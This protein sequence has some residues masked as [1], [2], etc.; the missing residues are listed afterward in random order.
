[1]KKFL[2]S[3]FTGLFIF[4]MLFSGAY[5]A[6]NDP[7]Q[8]IFNDNLIALKVPPL[9]ADGNIFVP[10]GEISDLLGM[11]VAW[12]DSTR[13]VKLTFR[14]TYADIR[15]GSNVAVI[16]GSQVPLD[17]PVKVMGG[18]TYIPLQF[19]SEYLDGISVDWNL[20]PKMIR[21]GGTFNGFVNKPIEGF[22]NLY[23]WAGK[24]I[25]SI[26]ENKVPGLNTGLP[27]LQSNV[28][29]PENL[30]LVNRSNPVPKNYV[31]K[32]LKKY[33]NT[34]VMMDSD[35][36]KALEEMMAAVSKARIGALWVS[37]GYRSYNIQQMLYNKKVR[38]CRS[39]YNAK[40]EDYAATIV[41]RPGE[42]EHQTG[43]AIDISNNGKLLFSFGNT[44]QGKWLKENAY[45]FGYVIRY[46]TSKF[47]VTGVQNEPWHL[48]FV[49][50]R[51]A[52]IMHDKNLCLE[53][54]V[55]Y[56]KHL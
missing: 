20:A 26:P 13:T 11:K 15:L 3:V 7:I 30:L 5:A 22:I 18:K 38:E 19:V 51:H 21:M 53:E 29:L 17:M 37:S 34:S 33:K 55:E 47:R 56:L 8:V 41:A 46:E 44:V 1:M 4:S 31:P 54:Y 2:L 12:I 25:K 52:R 36:L 40:A 27:S 24:V 10:V 43:L 14:N 23:N 16:N 45:K 42:S 39:Q 49:G 9:V 6:K 35:A 32:T 50:K 28:K 48:R